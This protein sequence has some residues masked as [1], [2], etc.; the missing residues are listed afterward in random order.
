MEKS[1]AYQ[2]DEYEEGLTFKK[3]GHFFA[4]GWLRMLVWVLAL[5]AATTVIVLPIKFY[6]K[7]EPMAQTTI[8]FVYEGIETGK[9]PS[10]GTLDTDN[11]ISTTVLANAIRDAGLGEVITDVSD[12]RENMRVEGVETDEYVRLVEAAANG[13]S[14]A[15]TTLRTYVMY[16]TRFN[17]IISKPKKLGLN[18]TQAKQLLNK[19]VANYFEDFKNRY[20]LTADDIYLLSAEQ[21]TLSE[22]SSDEFINIYD[23]YSNKLAYADEILMSIVSNSSVTAVMPDKSKLTKLQIELSGLTAELADFS[24]QVLSNNIWKDKVSAYK[25]LDILS[26]S[27]ENQ[28]EEQDKKIENLTTQIANFQPSSTHNNTPSGTVIVTTYPDEYYDLQKQLTTAYERKSALAYQAYEVTTRLGVIGDA[29][30]PTDETLKASALTKLK[31]IEGN[32]QNFA[33]KLTD[34]TDEFDALYVSSSVRQTRQ[35]VVTRKSSGLNVIIVY[36]VA[37]VAGLLIGGIITCVKIG[38]ASAKARVEAAADEKNADE[39][40]E[41]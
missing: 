36:G 17:V 5:V 12:L 23:T 40:T 6:Y 14:T 4:K 31:S 20:S 3:V 32:I 1:Y 27:L 38:K 24:S 9:D 33:D 16:P 8:E 30:E 37:V 25:S 13:D 18:D 7:S 28:I 10:G 29:T 26:K 22:N 41:D 35:P 2:E 19:V 21:F 34:M 39:K 15:Q 11:I